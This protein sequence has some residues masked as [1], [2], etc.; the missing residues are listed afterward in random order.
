MAKPH[1]LMLIT[2]TE[3]QPE[4][5]LQ[6]ISAIFDVKTDEIVQMVNLAI[7][8]PHGNN[9]KVWRFDTKQLLRLKRAL[10]L[11]RDLELDLSALA[12]ALELLDELEQ[13]RHKVDNLEQ[14]IHL[15]YRD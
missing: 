7:L 4:L 1:E 10:R 3:S 13:L 5:T 8:V 14:K 11:Q 2:I 15:L 12:L 6:E 9:P